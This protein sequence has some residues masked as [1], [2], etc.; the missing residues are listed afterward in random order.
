MTTVAVIPSYEPDERL[1]ELI[2]GLKGQR[3]D[4][5][6]VDD[7]SGERYRPIF[8]QATKDAVVLSY[9]V[10]QGKGHALKLGLRY[11]M[12]HYPCDTVVVTV[13]ADGQ[14][15]VEDTVRCASQAAGH[16]RAMVLGCRSFEASGVPLRSKVGNLVTRTVYRLTSG[17]RV[18]DTQTGLRAFSAGLI[19]FLVGVGG[20]RYEYEMNVLL[21]C[22]Q[23]NIEICEV[24]ISTIYEPGNASSHFHALRD[25]AR[26]YA[27]ILAFVA[28]SFASFLVDFSLFGLFVTCFAGMGSLGVFGA[29][30]LAR[31][32]SAAFNYTVNRSIVFR[33]KGSV[34][35]TAGRYAMVAAG[36]LLGNSVALLL[37]TGILGVSPLLAKIFVETCSFVAS[38]L[39][40]NRFVFARKEQ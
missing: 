39:M 7:G 37:L 24:P 34:A 33:S 28:S 9:G 5:V 6:V 30:V 20:S 10:N 17:E 11:V 38:W 2:S 22:P 14:H 4:R 25:S 29:N 15:T 23:H 35:Q 27:R 1:L 36:L 16:P 19:S 8:R 21:A 26:I 12:E 31:V 32:L 40:Q 13:D 3:V 18:S